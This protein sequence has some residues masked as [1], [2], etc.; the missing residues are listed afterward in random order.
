MVFIGADVA[1]FGSVVGAEWLAD[2][3]EFANGLR[4]GGDVGLMIR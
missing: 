2:E 3:S 1:E 4:G